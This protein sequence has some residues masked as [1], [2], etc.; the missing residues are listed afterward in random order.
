M[1]LTQL[2]YFYKV[3]QLEHITKASAEINIAQPALTKSIHKLEDEL[4]VTLFSH[5]G[6]NIKLTPW[7]I[8]L[9]EKINDPLNS[10]LNIKNE[11]NILKNN[12]HIKIGALAASTFVTNAILE[13]KKNNP[14][15]TFTLPQN[16]DDDC[17]ILVESAN[18]GYFEKIFIG[19]GSLYKDKIKKSSDLKNMPI[20][21]FTHFKE[22]RD[23]IDLFF[24]N[25]NIKPNIAFECDN[26][27]ILH[28]LILNN[29]GVGFIPEFTSGDIY[30]DLFLTRL[31]DYE[32]SR[33][34]KVSKNMFG[35]NNSDVV[36][37]FYDYLNDCFKNKKILKNY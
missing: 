31:N 19:S 10:I 5:C 14:D 17:D 16:N 8:W 37:S 27:N 20:I 22:L 11:I 18:D 36:N 35:L 28:E 6:R 1:E 24:T 23:S 4:G 33:Y 9:Y 26:L 7:G 34:I 25:I 29:N 32:L 13:F 12:K 30:N 3:A 15:V 21:T 2:Y